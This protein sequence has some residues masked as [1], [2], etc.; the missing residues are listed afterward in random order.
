MEVIRTFLYLN[1]ITWQYILYC[2]D[3]I[4]L[5]LIF[6]PIYFFASLFLSL[7]ALYPFYSLSD[8]PSVSVSL[9]LSLILFLSVSLS[10]S[11]SLYILSFFVFVGISASSMLTKQLF[12]KSHSKKAIKPKGFYV[13]VIYE[14]IITLSIRYHKGLY[15]W[16]IYEYVYNH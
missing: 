13:W 1:K 3:S 6:F 16:V 11:F 7:R 10:L 15:V 2:I 8:A 14:Y 4:V 12:Q 5:P 9:S